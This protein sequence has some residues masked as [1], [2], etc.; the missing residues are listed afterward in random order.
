MVRHCRVAAV[1]MAMAVVAGAIVAP[2]VASAQSSGNAKKT[3][4]IIG[5]YE[6]GG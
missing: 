4:H 2:G 5:A 3:L 1:V 6:T